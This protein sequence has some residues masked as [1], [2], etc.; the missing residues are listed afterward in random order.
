MPMKQDV[1]SNH[2]KR[3]PYVAEQRADGDHNNGGIDLIAEPHRINDIHEATEENGLRPLLVELNKPDGQFM[4]LGCAS[5]LD[6]S[7]HSYFEFTPRDRAEAENLDQ[8]ELIYSRW[9]SWVAEVDVKHPG[10]A[11]ALHDNAVWETRTFSFRGNEPQHLITVFH[12]A[13]DVE[14]HRTLAE[15]FVIF[16]RSIEQSS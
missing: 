11:K 9:L 14:N 10:F 1:D 15:Y 12:R 4:S 5:G 3:W 6:G 13:P 16:L 7:Y 2:F 8:M